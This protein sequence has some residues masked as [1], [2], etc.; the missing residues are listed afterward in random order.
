V[1]APKPSPSREEVQ[2][3]REF[4]R[5]VDSMGRRR[6]IV[7]FR[8]Q[9]HSISCAGELVGPEYD[10]KDFDAFLTDFRKV[11]MSKSE[12]VYLTKVLRTVGKYASEP[13]RSAL[14]L[15]HVNIVPLVEGTRTRI[16][17]SFERDGKTSNLTPQKILSTLVNGEIFHVGPEDAD[18]ARELREQNPLHYLWPTLHFFVIPIYYACVALCQAIQY[19]CLTVEGPGTAPDAPAEPSDDGK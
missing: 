16:I 8:E 13:M 6:F 12:S 4:V 11:A 19:E 15:C 9:D 17:C 7:R 10:K 3:L 18:Q 1:D 2:Q 5:V 14:K